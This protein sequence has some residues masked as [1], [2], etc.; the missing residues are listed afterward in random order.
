[1]NKNTLFEFRYPS[2]I[3]EL[4]NNSE[5][6][7]LINETDGFYEIYDGYGHND[8]VLQIN[9]SNLLIDETF[10]ELFHYK[11]IKK[12]QVLLFLHQLPPV[13]LMHL[14]K[15]IFTNLTEKELLA[16]EELSPNH[17]M[18][19]NPDS[20]GM[21][22]YNDSTVLIHLENHKKAAIEIESEDISVLGYSIGWERHFLDG[23]YQTIAHELFHL[24]QF[25]PLIDAYIPE[26]EEVAENFC[27]ELF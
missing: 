15:I 14:K 18:D 17:T 21:A 13:L 22:V 25:N 1:M 12:E 24:A 19:I 16:L 10:I 20:I 23:I 7:E 9:K 26:G 2:N 3:V 11:E 4:I 27:R 8:R 6:V 5:G